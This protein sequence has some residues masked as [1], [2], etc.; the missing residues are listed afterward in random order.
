MMEPETYADVGELADASEACP[1]CGNRDKDRL[2][3]L[4]DGV[5]DEIEC[6]QCGHHYHITR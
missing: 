5:D 2:I 6:E 1:N 4:N 3:W